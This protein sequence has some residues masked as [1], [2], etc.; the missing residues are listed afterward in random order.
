MDGEIAR[1]SASEGEWAATGERAH[2][3]RHPQHQG[4]NSQGNEHI[5]GENGAATISVSRT[6]VSSVSFC[7]VE[8]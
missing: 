7:V 1:T 6:D 5:A 8:N 4:C 3:E 2:C